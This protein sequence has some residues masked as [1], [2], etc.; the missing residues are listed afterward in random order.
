MTHTAPET[1]YVAVGRGRRAIFRILGL[2]F[3]GLGIIGIFV[4]G[5]PTTINV[6]VAGYFFS[7][8]SPRFDAW[9]TNHRIFGPIITDYR[10]GVG[11][12]R[13]AKTI[14]VS[15][16]TISI[17]FSTWLILRAGAPWFVGVIMALAW[18]YAVW[19]VLH[20]NTKPA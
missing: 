8:S 15:A 6:I 18:A 13:R 2:F 17:A 1:T 14:S 11:F 10:S 20:Q 5:I 7:R 19:F 9:L 4:P 16:I 12:T 3:A